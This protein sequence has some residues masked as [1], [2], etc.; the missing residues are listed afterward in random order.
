[1]RLA[2]LKIVVKLSLIVAVAFLGIAL[3]TLFVLS[4]IND[5]MFKDRQVKTRA[6]VELAHSTVAGYAKQAD[7]GILSPD[8]AKAQALLALKSMRYEG[9]E[10]IWVNDMAPIMVMHPIKPELDGKDLSK[11]ADPTGKLLF[12]E[13]VNTVKAKGEGF[14]E[15][16]WPKPGLEKPVRKISYV[17]GF[18]PWGW[19]IGSGIYLDDAEAAF[20][21]KALAS[22]AIVA[23]I[24][25]LV[26]VL[27]V[28][29]ARNTAR[30][31]VQTTREMQRLAEGDTNVAIFGCDRKDEVGDMANAVQVFKENM[32]RNREMEAQ[33]RARQAH[34][35]E[36]ARQRDELTADFDKMITD[37]LVKVS[38]T[39]AH[40]HGASDG[41]HAAAEQ[42][43]RQGAAVAAAAD[44][45]SANVQTVASATEELGASTQEISRRVQ[46]TTRITQEAVAGIQEASATMDGL[47]QA[48]GKIGEI[49]KLINDIASQTNL[50]ALNATIEAA[51]AGDAG[52]GFAVV[53]NEVKNLANQ[54]A[55]ATEEIGSQVA[56]MQ[57]STE[58]ALE[59]TKRVA[60]VIAR[61]DEVVATI[62]SAAEQQNAATHEIARNIQQASQGTREVTSSISEVSQAAVETGR[63]SGAMSD[64]AEEL[65]TEAD[66]LK[67]RVEHFLAEVR[68]A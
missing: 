3:V 39:V 54:T 42:T 66:S 37:M 38:N 55:K 11:N 65:K 16:L 51:R 4:D 28:L 17:K 59:A 34:D 21:S 50:L 23:M 31:I 27:S 62:A 12:I 13:F 32:I 48:T 67:G 15:Y 18:A 46:E 58:Q 35:L 36:R 5:T 57:G 49:V 7:D 47:A 68:V 56:G 61:V 22:G 20:R 40:V 33:A 41:L 19:V 14:V 1:M 29:V 60:D 25:L 6:V 8:A 44:Q 52:K 26:I 30:P 43:S 64:V 2:D 24:T 63:L 10:Y 45:A 9:S 53:A